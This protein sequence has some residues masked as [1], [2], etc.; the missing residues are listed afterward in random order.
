ME[1]DRRLPSFLTLFFRN[2]PTLNREKSMAADRIMA[3][4]RA[5]HSERSRGNSEGALE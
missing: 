1:L 5:C 3:P 2:V 4:R